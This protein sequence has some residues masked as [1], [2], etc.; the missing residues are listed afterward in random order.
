MKKF[1]VLLTGVTTMLVVLGTAFTISAA[2]KGITATV[3]TTMASATYNYGKPSSSLE[4]EIYFEEEHYQTHQV[5][6]KSE[7]E[8]AYGGYSSVSMRRNADDAYFYNKII[9]TGYCNGEFDIS[10]G[11]VTP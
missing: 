3:T 1:K 7:S 5:F 11:E 2:T 4:V 8:Y 10:T 6:C 9:A